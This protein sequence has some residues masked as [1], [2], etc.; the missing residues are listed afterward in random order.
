MVAIPIGP[1]QQR[2]ATAASPKYLDRRGRPD[3][4]RDLLNHTC[5]RG[6]FPSG[7]MISPWEFERDG[8]TGIAGCCYIQ[9]GRAELGSNHAR[10][11]ASPPT[12]A[13]NSPKILSGPRMNLLESSMHERRRPT[14]LTHR[15]TPNQA[16]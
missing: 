16:T 2:F 5:M 3:H 4:P 15:R 7:A 11:N 13:R 1:R 6:K 10:N 14:M 12:A 9:I 8:E